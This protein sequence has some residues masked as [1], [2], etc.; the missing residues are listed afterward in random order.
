MQAANLFMQMSGDVA[1]KMPKEYRRWAT[2][3]Q[4][5]EVL[6]VLTLVLRPELLDKRRELRQ[7]VTERYD[8]AYGDKKAPK[9]G[10]MCAELPPDGEEEPNLEEL[11]KSNGDYR[12]IGLVM[13]IIISVICKLV[14]DW[15][16]N[17]LADRKKQD[18][19]VK[20][21]TILGYL[22][23]ELEVGTKAVS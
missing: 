14:A 20:E 11:V 19:L 16:A 4:R 9:L 15:I 18:P 3:K 17:K 21:E 7:I 23:A 12:D 8:E 10:P 1:A 6:E 22:L 13:T 2:L 5:V